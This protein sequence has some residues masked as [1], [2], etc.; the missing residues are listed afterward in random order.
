MVQR[1][2][3]QTTT[4]QQRQFI[5]RQVLDAIDQIQEAWQRIL[6]AREETLLA[7]TNYKA[8][9]KQFLAGS[10][11]STDVLTAADFLAEAQLREVNALA[12]YEVAKIDLAFVTGTLLGSGKVELQPYVAT[13]TAAASVVQRVNKKL[14]VL[15]VTPAPPVAPASHA[16]P[17]AAEAEN[18]AA[19]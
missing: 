17:A 9:Q 18:V 16:E 1:A 12:A 15:Q 19:Q 5:E 7:A 2:L 8:E 13:P 10:R 14:A 3:T 6:A 4:D 11:T